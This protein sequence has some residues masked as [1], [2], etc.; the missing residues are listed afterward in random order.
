[1]GGRAGRRCYFPTRLIAERL[2]RLGCG[3]SA[4]T[5]AGSH[6]FPFRSLVLTES[7]PSPNESRRDRPADASFISGNDRDSLRDH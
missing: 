7:R 6:R 3:H 2:P 5:G 1:M 4:G